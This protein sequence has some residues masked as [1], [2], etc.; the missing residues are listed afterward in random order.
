VSEP[1][2]CPVCDKRSYHPEDLRQGFCNG[3]RAFTG[4]CSIGGCAER[5]ARIA[6]NVA[7]CAP[8]AEEI[9]LS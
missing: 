9:G 7:L 4:R 5:P 2:R 6:G 1:F 3:C 8:H